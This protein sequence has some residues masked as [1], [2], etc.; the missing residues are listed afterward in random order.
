MSLFRTARVLFVKKI[1]SIGLLFMMFFLVACSENIDSNWIERK[2]LN[3]ASSFVSLDGNRVHYRD[4]GAG[5]VIVLI[6]G[7]AS[8]LH[9]WDQWANILTRHYR[10]IRMDL[11]GFGLTGPDHSERYEV[12]DDVAFLKGF[13]DKLEITKAHFVGSSLGGRI[14]WQYA[15]QYPNDVHTL[16]LVNSLGY[17][18]EKWPPPIQM[19][20]WPVFDEVM[21]RFSPRFMYEIGLKDIYYDESLVNDNLVDRYYEISRYPGNLAAFPARVKASLDKDS[22]LIN[23]IKVPT[24]I[25]WGEED[26]YFPVESAYRFDQDIDDSHL[27]IYPYIG[28]LPMEEAP[29]RSVKDYLGFL[30]KKG[31]KDSDEVRYSSLKERMSF[32]TITGVRSIF[33]Q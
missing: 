9:T 14:A 33:D 4:E 24:L 2:Y 25:M 20:Q 29:E 30:E 1:V 10:V 23:Q 15:L 22:N 8:S 21:K 12:S 19:A 28:H 27:V 18:Q 7:T 13:L 32:S 26:L 6:H 16:A 31:V 11:T 17:P 3:D 5:E